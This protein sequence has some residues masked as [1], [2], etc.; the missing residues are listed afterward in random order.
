[1]EPE[2]CNEGQ[3]GGTTPVKALR[4]GRSPF[5]CCDMCGN[6]WE[7]TESEYSGGQTR[8]AILKGG[9]WFKTR[10]PKSD[11]DG[12]PQAGRFGV[13]FLLMWPGLDR[14]ATVGFRWAA[15]LEAPGR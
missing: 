12:V 1:M 2:R 10:G 9:S 14:C 15:P 4:A 8:F 7:W 6:T 13:K 11:T 3:A 5:G